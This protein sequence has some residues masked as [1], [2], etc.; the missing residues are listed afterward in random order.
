MEIATKHSSLKT[1]IDLVFIVIAAI[2]TVLIYSTYSSAEA[3]KTNRKIISDIGNINTTLE[4]ILSS[5]IDI[6]TGTRGYAITGNESYLE[7]YNNGGKNVGLW[8]DSLKSMVNSYPNQI[9]KLDSIEKLI[10]SKRLISSET[11]LKRKTESKDEAAKLV[12]SGRGKEIMDSIRVIISDFQKTQMN[13]LSVKLSD[14]TEK[15]RTRNLYFL[16]FVSLTV[17][18]LLFSYYLIRKNASKLIDKEELQ[19]ELITELSVQNKQM[20]DFANI[21]SHNLRS[22]STNITS[23]ISIIDEKSTIDDYKMIFEMLKKVSQNLNETLNHLMEILHIRRNKTLEIEQILFEEIFTKTTES[24]Q[25][26]IM[27]SHAEIKGDF[28]NAKE[29]LYP[30]IYLESIFHNLVSNAIKYRHPERKP[31][32]FVKTE[33]ADNTI[34]LTVKDNGLGIDLTKHGSKMFGMHKVF[35]NHP[36]AK[37]IGLFIT[38]AQIE[39]LNGKISVASEAGSGTAFTVTFSIK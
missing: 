36:D 25:G 11:V 24:L 38:K 7:A 34:I 4:K 3:V 19:G 39:S 29:I 1:K 32:I 13:I 14:T 31:E 21:T 6:E 18:L 15:I 23:L 5:T 12:E 35:H 28:S 8:M 33:I 2:F 20:N 17:G 10:H 26:E 22:P 9:Q 16:F 30:R 37:G 27:V